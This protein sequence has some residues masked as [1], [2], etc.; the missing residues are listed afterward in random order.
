MSLKA[1]HLIFVNALS[2]LCL[3][4]AIWK[5]RDFVSPTGVALDAVFAAAAMLAGI[6]VIFYGW[7]FLKK[8]RSV[9]YL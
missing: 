5:V 2:A 7:Y 4:T 3:G 1:V 9:G 6:A 8:M